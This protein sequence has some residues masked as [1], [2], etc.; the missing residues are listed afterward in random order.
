MCRKEAESWWGAGTEEDSKRSIRGKGDAGPV[1]GQLKPSTRGTDWK[2]MGPSGAPTLYQ[3]QPWHQ[4]IIIKQWGG[5]SDGDP[6][7]TTLAS[8]EFTVNKHSLGE[9]ESSPPAPDPSST[10]RSLQNKAQVSGQPLW[11]PAPSPSLPFTGPPTLPP[12]VASSPAPHTLSPISL[13]ALF[14]LFTLFPSPVSNC[15]HS[16][17]PLYDFKT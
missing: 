9:T 6:R 7:L 10:T 14:A 3:E 1:A 16:H 5:S 15:I 4:E 11:T 2:V 13:K 12:R 17:H 8:P